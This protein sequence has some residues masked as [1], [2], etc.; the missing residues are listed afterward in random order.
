M[1]Q[2]TGSSI[3]TAQSDHPEDSLDLGNL[4]GNLR[5]AGGAIHTIENG[6]PVRRSYQELRRHCAAAMEILRGWGVAPGVRV[7]IFAPNSYYWL[8][9]DLALLE[10][11]AVSVAFTDDFKESL[12]EETLKKYQVRILLT[13]KDF[14]ARFSSLTTRVIIIDAIDQNLSLLSL[15]SLAPAQFDPDTLGHVFSSGSSGGLKGLIISRRGVA[16]C[17]PPLLKT[18]GIRHSDRLLLFLPM[19]NFQQRFLCYGA[20]WFD[21]DIILVEAV[22]LFKAMELLH[23][24][25]LLAPPIFYQMV[26]AEFHKQR[27]WKKTSCKIN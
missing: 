3:A 9:Y 15:P 23:P 18:V 24:T 22:H 11:G 17:L 1:L 10:I 7:G 25:V 21:F 20:L 27:S 6:T 16:G 2:D 26:H 13:C 14:R 4:V 8:V 12:D 19:S 5:H